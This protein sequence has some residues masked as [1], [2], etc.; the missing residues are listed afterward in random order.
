[1]AQLA[2]VNGIIKKAMNE[3]AA[4]KMLFVTLITYGT[5]HTAK[6]STTEL[7][8][9]TAHGLKNGNII[10]FKSGTLNAA[11]LAAGL[12]EG[13]FYY[14]LKE[15]ANTFGL[16][17]DGVTAT[18]L[19]WSGGVEG[20]YVQVTEIPQVEARATVALGNQTDRV[21]EDKTSRSIKLTAGCTVNGTAYSEK[22]T[23]GELNAGF[24]LTEAEVI[25]A[26]ATVSVLTSKVTTK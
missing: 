8:E 7:L 11:A 26:A 3:A 21:T 24:A 23:G 1:M 17:E 22:L 2:T 4:L 5:E 9:F 6:E 15:A 25:A 10:M 13:V 18:A 14:V 19:K 16:A 12:E 20:K